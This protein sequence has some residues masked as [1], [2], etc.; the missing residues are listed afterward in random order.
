VFHIVPHPSNG[1]SGDSIGKQHH[2]SDALGCQRQSG[3]R[4]RPNH[5]SSSGPNSFAMIRSGSGLNFSSHCDW[6]RDIAVMLL[7]VFVSL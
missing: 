6:S 5:S 7:A 3:H 4:I 1:G 2:V